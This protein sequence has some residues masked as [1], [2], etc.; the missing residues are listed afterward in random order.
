MFN[1]TA[2]TKRVITT[3]CVFIYAAMVVGFGIHCLVVNNQYE[4]AKKEYIKTNQC[5]PI[6]QSPLET[7]ANRAALYQCVQSKVYL[8]GPVVGEIKNPVKQDKFNNAVWPGMETSD[9]AVM[10]PKLVTGVH[11]GSLVLK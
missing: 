10:F 1:F 6:W 11:N 7:E 8:G 2:K 4:N 9:K 5:E 3:A